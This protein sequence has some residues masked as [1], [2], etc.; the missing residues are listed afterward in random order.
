MSAAVGFFLGTQERV[1]NGYGKRAIG[2]R[3]IEVLL[4]MS[5]DI[6]SDFIQLLN[7]TI[8]HDGKMRNWQNSFEIYL[9]LTFL[10]NN[11]E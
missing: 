7:A 3:T 5:L 6:D 10:F 9:T 4:C 8:V 11:F 2:V 1:R